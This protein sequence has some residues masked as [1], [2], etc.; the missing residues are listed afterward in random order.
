MHSV[1]VCVCARALQRTSH[2]HAQCPLY[3]CLSHGTYVYLIQHRCVCGIVQF[4]VLKHL[5]K[6][7]FACPALCI[8]VCM[9]M[10]LFWQQQSCMSFY[11]VHLRVYGLSIYVFAGVCIYVC[12]RE[13]L[14]VCVFTYIHTYMC[15]YMDRVLVL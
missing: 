4:V 9:Y 5:G 6:I 1:C 12:V 15:T 13:C 8:Q 11:S 14:H 2:T 7:I 10:C 3:I